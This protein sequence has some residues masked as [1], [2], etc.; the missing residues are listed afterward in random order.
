MLKDIAAPDVA[1]VSTA[2]AAA[3]AVDAAAAAAAAATA[4]GDVA[5][6]A[7]TALLF[8]LLLLPATKSKNIKRDSQGF[9]SITQQSLQKHCS[10]KKSKIENGI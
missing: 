6:A 2:A 4:V 8:L 5:A 10:I 7:A 9:L 1:E 3:A